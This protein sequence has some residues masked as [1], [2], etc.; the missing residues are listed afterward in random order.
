MSKFKTG[1]GV[2]PMA[3]KDGSYVE[4]INYIST[5]ELGAQNKFLKINGSIWINKNDITPEEIDNLIVYVP[6]TA[7]SSFYD[8]K[9]KL[10]IDHE[11]WSAVDSQ[12][13]YVCNILMDQNKLYP[14]ADAFGDLRMLLWYQG[15]GDG[16]PMHV[17]SN[18]VLEEIEDAIIYDGA[19]EN[20]GV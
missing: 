13:Y 9:F 20:K 1:S 6:D 18:V 19:F 12:S 14:L 2:F 8:S 17:Q 3:K 10:E 16:K 7:I 15:D 4:I 5:G 11:E